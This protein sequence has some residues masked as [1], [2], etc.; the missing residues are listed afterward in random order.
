MW[1]SRSVFEGLG[2]CLSV[3][4]I[5]FVCV[6]ASEPGSSALKRPRLLFSACLAPAVGSSPDSVR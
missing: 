1:L 6:I 5:V 3:L 4:V 2:C